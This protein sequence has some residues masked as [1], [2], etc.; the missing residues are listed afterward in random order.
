MAH[1]FCPGSGSGMVH[2][3]LRAENPGIVLPGAAMPFEFVRVSTQRVGLT[4]ISDDPAILR[5]VDDRGGLCGM[6]DPGGVGS[7]DGVSAAKTVKDAIS[8]TAAFLLPGD[9]LRT[10]LA[11]FSR[12]AQETLPVIDNPED[13]RVIGYLSEAYALRRYA[14]ELERHRGTRQDDAGIFSPLLSARHP[15]PEPWQNR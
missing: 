4:R 3:Q 2:A 6:V 5:I 11:R 15:E 12:S 13:R 14:H 7:P 1:L 9:D 8:E 10:A